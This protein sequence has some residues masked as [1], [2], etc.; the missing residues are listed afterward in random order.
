MDGVKISPC[1]INIAT[2]N[3]LSL[4]L[5][6]DDFEQNSIIFSISFAFRP[7]SWK[8]FSILIHFPQQIA[9]KHNE[10]KVIQHPAM[11]E[12]IKTKWRLFG[13]LGASGAFTFHFAYV[14]LWTVLAV[15][16]PRDGAYYTK[17]HYRFASYIFFASTTN[18]PLGLSQ[19]EQNL[20]VNTWARMSPSFKLNLV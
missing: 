17:D 12:L 10:L 8:W 16:L 14:C 6:F 11:Q 3:A 5:I 15:T 19:P 13:R 18:F 2:E 4:F 20:S 7:M 9:V 1:F